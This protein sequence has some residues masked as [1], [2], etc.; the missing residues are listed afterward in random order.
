MRAEDIKT[1]VVIGA[2]AMGRQIAMNSA[3]NG[4]GYQV[5]LCDSF[6]AALEQSRAWVSEY[7]AGRESRAASHRKSQTRWPPG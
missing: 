7:L 4:P 5:I 2:G 3:L 6:P 1:V